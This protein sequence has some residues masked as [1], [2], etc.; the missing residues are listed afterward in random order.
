MF[1]VFG[2]FPDRFAVAATVRLN[3]RVCRKFLRDLFGDYEV[4]GFCSSECCDLWAL[5]QVVRIL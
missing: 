3:C 1:G 2:W 5:A 4:E